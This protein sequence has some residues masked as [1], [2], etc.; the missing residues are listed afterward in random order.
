VLP[1]WPLLLQ[2]IGGARLRRPAQLDL[3]FSAAISSTGI[4]VAGTLASLSSTASDPPEVD[5]HL[6]VRV[7][8]ARRRGL[9]DCGT[10]D[11]RRDFG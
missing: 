10:F 5:L 6:G 9:V 11:S 3:E 1:R 4:A 2:G 8:G 7:A